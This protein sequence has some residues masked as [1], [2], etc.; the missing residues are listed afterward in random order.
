MSNHKY[1][2]NYT[3]KE[4]EDFLNSNGEKILNEMELNPSNL[5]ENNYYVYIWFSQT[6]P[7]KIFYVG[8]GTR[9]R[10]LHILNDIKAVKN[11]KTNNHRF[12]QYKIIEE[13]YGIDYSI[14][15]E[16]LSEN[17]ALF[18]EQALKYFLLEKGEVLLNVEGIPT[19]NLPEG[20]EGSSILY[21]Y[22]YLQ[23]SKFRMR[24]LND[25]DIPYFDEFSFDL[26][27]NVYIYPYFRPIDSSKRDN[28]ENII[29]DYCEANGIKLF[30][31]A[32]KKVETVIVCGYLPE[33]RYI[34]YREKKYNILSS[35][36][37]I[38]FI[39]NS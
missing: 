33:D 24:Y 28:T 36:D 1:K 20:W 11:K 14:V 35:D 22:P 34:E 26:L 2:S 12:E 25:F 8:K 38:K 15:F 18:Y 17:E 13:L 23:K 19:E 37:V 16:N 27:N 6:D 3:L 30:N 5:T 4:F 32:L 31:R 9:K 29:I 39:L 7:I 21:E 10:Y